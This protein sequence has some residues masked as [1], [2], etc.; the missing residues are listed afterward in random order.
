M[1]R[2]DIGDD[3]YL[4]RVRPLQDA[5]ELPTGIYCQV[6]GCSQAGQ[7]MHH[8]APKQLFG[9][10][11]DDWPMGLLCAV[12]HRLWHSLIRSGRALGDDQ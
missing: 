11:A 6:R 3:V 2:T 7:E 12:H 9:D 4:V 8:W 10:E 5:Q 1:F